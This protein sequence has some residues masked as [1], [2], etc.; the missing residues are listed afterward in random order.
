MVQGVTSGIGGVRSPLA[1]KQAKT[2]NDGNKGE[3]GKA[4]D[5][6]GGWARRTS[7]R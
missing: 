3:K 4:G 2:N 7:R 1:N 5:E 6:G